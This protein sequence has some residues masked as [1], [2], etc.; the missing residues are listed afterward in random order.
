VLDSLERPDGVAELLALVRVV[1]QAP[2][3]FE[4]AVRQILLVP[5]TELLAE[6]LLL[7]V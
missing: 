7:F 1:R 5:F 4:P 3:P 2:V 6:L